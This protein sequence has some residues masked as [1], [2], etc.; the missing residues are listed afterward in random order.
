MKLHIKLFSLCGLILLVM[1]G[2]DTA[3]Q[4]KTVVDFWG[5]TDL[6]D[7]KVRENDP[8]GNAKISTLLG[9]ADPNEQHGM[10]GAAAFDVLFKTLTWLEKYYPASGS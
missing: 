3:K 2:Y 7:R 5:P 10:K 6:T 4:I 9:T 8:A 1:D